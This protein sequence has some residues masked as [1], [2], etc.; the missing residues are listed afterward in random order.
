[1]RALG[2]EAYAELCSW[3]RSWTR[4]KASNTFMWESTSQVDRQTN[5]RPPLQEPE[6]VNEMSVGMKNSNN[7]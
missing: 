1:M 6:Q 4:E 3:E 7:L 5:E 2:L